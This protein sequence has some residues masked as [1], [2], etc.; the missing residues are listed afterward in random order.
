MIP[1]TSELHRDSADAWETLTRC[2]LCKRNSADPSLSQL[3][4]EHFVVNSMKG[5]RR[6]SR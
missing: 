4:L 2:P 5:L 3:T 1:R 6:L